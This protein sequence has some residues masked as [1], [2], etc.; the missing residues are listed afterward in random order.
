MVRN[1]GRVTRFVVMAM[2]QGARAESLGLS[3]EAAYSWG[4]NRAIFI[5]AA[6][7]GFRGTRST[8]GAST[9]GPSSRP[10]REVYRLGDDEAYRNPA[11]KGLVFTI[12]DQDQTVAEFEGSVAA[13]FG[14]TENFQAAWSEARKVVGEFDRATLESRERFYSEVYRP[15]RDALSDDWTQRYSPPPKKK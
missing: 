13:R 2:L 11:A 1:Q 14:T 12:G 15:R 9:E 4:L 7:R 10:A 8:T 6:G 3:R 5:A